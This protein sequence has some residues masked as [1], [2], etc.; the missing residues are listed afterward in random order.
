MLSAIF[1]SDNITNQKNTEAIEVEPDTFVSARVIEHQPEITQSLEVVKDQVI[2]ALKKRMSE[3][4]ALEVGQN[5]LKQLQ[6]SPS[7]DVQDITWDDAKSVSY[8]QSQG[9]G[10]EELRAIFKADT[11]KLPTYVGLENSDGFTLIR[12]N[13]IIDPSDKDKEKFDAFKKQLQQMITQE[14]TGAYLAAI[15]KQYEVKINQDF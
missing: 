2:G 9:L 11:K 3:A 5:K 6:T 8:M 4:K 10:N 15:R 13:K 7:S 14:E 1:S 12:I